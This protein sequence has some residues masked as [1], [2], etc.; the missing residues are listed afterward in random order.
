MEIIEINLNNI[1]IK[2]SKTEDSF[3]NEITMKRTAGKDVTGYTYK[4]QIEAHVHANKRKMLTN[5]A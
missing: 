5:K 4:Q 3:N 1:K 2:E